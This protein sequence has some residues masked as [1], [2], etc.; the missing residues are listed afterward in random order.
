MKQ[1]RQ[2]QLCLESQVSR[3]SFLIAETVQ[4]NLYLSF[5]NDRANLTILLKQDIWAQYID[6]IK[7]Y[8][9]FYQTAM[10][11]MQTAYN[12][13]STSIGKELFK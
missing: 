6:F 2:I 12:Q 3:H 11:Q 13:M 1:H 10:Q 9:S 4:K 5:F 7:E 8:T